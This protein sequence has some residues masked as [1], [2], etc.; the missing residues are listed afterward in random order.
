MQV[1]HVEGLVR[2]GEREQVAHL[3]A[4]VLQTELGRMCR[5]L[6]HHLGGGVDAHHL[7]RRHQ[8]GKVGRDGARAAPDVEQGLTGTQVG[9]QVGR[10]SSQPCARYGCAAPI[11]GVRACRSCH[12]VGVPE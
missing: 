4:H 1:D 9:Q 11:R 12:H 7:A 10:G 6:G 8:E 3:E 5:R 2:V